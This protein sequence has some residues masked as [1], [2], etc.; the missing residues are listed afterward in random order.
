MDYRD[1]NISFLSRENRYR[2]SVIRSEEVKRRVEG[3]DVNEI[4]NNLTLVMKSSIIF[5]GEF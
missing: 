3:N 1:G 4:E 5:F 2:F